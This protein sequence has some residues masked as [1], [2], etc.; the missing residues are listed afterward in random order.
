MSFPFVIPR[1][2]SFRLSL[3]MRWDILTGSKTPHQHKDTKAGS[4]SH[5]HRCQALWDTHGCRDEGQQAGLLLLFGCCSVWETGICAR[6]V[7]NR[8]S[9]C[10]ETPNSSANFSPPPYWDSLP[11]FEVSQPRSISVLRQLATHSS[12]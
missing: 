10:G 5:S 7:S 9:C 1:S 4:D 11:D 6:L 12:G 2:F 3:Q 8:A